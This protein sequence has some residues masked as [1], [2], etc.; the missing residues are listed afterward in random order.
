MFVWSGLVPGFATVFRTR[1]W[2]VNFRASQN[3]SADWISFC[4]A[5]EQVLSRVR[6]QGLI[7]TVTL[8]FKAIAAV[9]IMVLLLL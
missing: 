6:S 9:N 1:I 3:C 2:F 8:V 5:T 4:Q 7:G